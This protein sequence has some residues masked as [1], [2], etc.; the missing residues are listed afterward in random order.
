MKSRERAKS[1]GGGAGMGTSS[2]YEQD[3]NN[4]VIEYLEFANYPSSSKAFKDECAARGRPVP[5][6]SNIK[7]DARKQEI[8]V[9][10][11]S[12]FVS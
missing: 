10:F 11:K 2:G 7:S 6:V 12:F 3:L 8:Q 5:Q 1:S 9:K 4:I